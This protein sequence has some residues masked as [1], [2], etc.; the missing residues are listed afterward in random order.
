MVG[1]TVEVLVEERNVRVPPQVMGRTT[2]GYIVYLEGEI[3][4]L[5]GK[6]VNVEIESSQ[7]WYLSGKIIE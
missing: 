2:H 1:R 5:Q 6:L 7:N 4:E 3:D